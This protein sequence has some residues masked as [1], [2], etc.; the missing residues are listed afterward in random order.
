MLDV[1]VIG[2]GIT[3]LAAAFEL[4][5]RGCSFH[6]FESA[7]R[8]GGVVWTERHDGYLIDPG[9][10]SIL[11]TK[12]GGIA[13]C[14]ELG[15]DARLIPMRTPRT[16][17][18]VR[19]GVLHPIPEAAVL[20][21]PTTWRGL[22]RSHLFTWP[23]RLRMA[24]DLVLPRRAPVDDESIA[25]FV[26][27]R[28]GREAVTYLADPL[29]AGI[30]MGTADRL[31]VRA[32]FPRLADAEARHG[33]V[34]RGLGRE[35]GERDPA[36]PFRSFNLGIG[37]LITTLTGRL[38]P[39][40]IS[41]A[42]PVVALTGSGPYTLTTGTAT[43]EARSVILAVPA[44]AAAKLLE[45]GDP[46]AAAICAE[47]RYN[48]SLTVFA[49]YDRAQVKHP[50]AGSGFVVPR[51]ER[52]FDISAATWI[53]SK[54]PGRAPQGQV[55][56]RAFLG[57]SRDPRATSRTDEESIAIAYRDLGR[58]LGISGQPVFTRVYRWREASPQYEVGHLRRI[59]RLAALLDRLPGLFV[60]GSG[61][62]GTGISDCIDSGRSAARAATAIALRGV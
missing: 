20:G 50:L 5:S 53:S 38:P 41:L 55:L 58:L 17:F 16:A 43:V 23:G 2:G 25:S 29:L 34:L 4:A 52:T 32:L 39:D 8:P 21:V 62:H 57:G 33:S 44:F 59:E 37:E 45:T 28:F 6:L 47:I 56:L 10:D 49:A 48:S 7:A 31:S 26:A 46:E 1:A 40:R 42:T 22:A 3:G 24:A 18:V 19:N 9:P 13:L 15:L 27:R 35:S 11:A 36:G 30:H 14:R 51:V 60:T 61:F 12:P 54:W